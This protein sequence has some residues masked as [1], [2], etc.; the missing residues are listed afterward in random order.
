MLCVSHGS[1][2]LPHW[3]QFP[4][5]ESCNSFCCCCHCCLEGSS[6]IHAPLRSHAGAVV[7]PRLIGSIL[8]PAQWVRT[9]FIAPVL[10]KRQQRLREV[11]W[12]AQ[13]HA[14]GSGGTGTPAQPPGSG[15]ASTRTCT[16]QRA[17]GVSLS[18]LFPSSYCLELCIVLPARLWSFIPS[19]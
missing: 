11:R 4:Q 19:S 5:R 2:S 18:L 13:G 9:C 7:M 10:Q 15:A 3:P 8:P 14:A 12:L 17:F 6:D 16:L 1:L